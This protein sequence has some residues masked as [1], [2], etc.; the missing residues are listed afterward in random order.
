MLNE[1]IRTGGNSTCERKVEN[2]MLCVVYIARLQE[3]AS[4]IL[5]DEE[6]AKSLFDSPEAAVNQIISVNEFSYRVMVFILVMK[7]KLLKPLGLVVFQLRPIF[8]SQ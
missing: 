8:L 4:V 2:E 7:L 5:L 1:L 6:L 3:F